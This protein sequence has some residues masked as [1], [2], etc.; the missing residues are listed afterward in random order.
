NPGSHPRLR[1][2]VAVLA[3]GTGLGE[4][5][6]YWDGTQHHPVASEGGHV[7][8]APR[9]D[10]EIALLRY[11]RGKFQSHVSYERVL[12]GPGFY[13]LY[14]FLRDEGYHPEPAWLADKLQDG[15]PSV[16]VTQT[17]LAGQDPL[18]VATL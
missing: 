18:C 6:L 15:D 3:A 16:T 5:F 10:L 9:N 17:A 12:S 13:N 1:G 8:F 14:T 4:A 2:N 7:D 11:L